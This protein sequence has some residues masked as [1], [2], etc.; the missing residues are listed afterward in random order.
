MTALS[1]QE[2]E[3]YVRSW[4]DIGPRITVTLLLGFVLV[5]GWTNHV[6]FSRQAW[7]ETAWMSLQTLLLVGALLL[8]WLN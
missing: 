1:A 4:M 7:P 8:I 5:T 3:A 6:F 2:M